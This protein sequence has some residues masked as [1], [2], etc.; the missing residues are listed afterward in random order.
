MDYSTG[1]VKVYETFVPSNNVLKIYFNGNL[2]EFV[3][4]FIEE[5][6]HRLKDCYWM[7]TKENPIAS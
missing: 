2:D 6:G 3:E 4:E 1:K 7:M 5:Q